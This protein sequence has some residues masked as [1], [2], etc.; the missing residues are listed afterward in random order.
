MRTLL[1]DLFR[2]SV[3]SSFG[4]E[5]EVMKMIDNYKADPRENTEKSF[6]NFNVNTTTMM[7]QVLELNQSH[8]EFTFK[9]VKQHELFLEELGKL[10][11]EV[12]KIRE[13]IMKIM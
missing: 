9:F 12:R 13:E 7:E 11:I 5:N 6:T 3:S 8:K 2:N 4:D 1:D 10:R